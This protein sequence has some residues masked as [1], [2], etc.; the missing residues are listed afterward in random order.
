MRAKRTLGTLLLG[1]GFLALAGQARAQTPSLLKDINTTPP[2][3][4]ASYPYGY[5]PTAPY[6]EQNRFPRIGPFFY[7]RAKTE[8]LATSSTGA[9]GSPAAPGW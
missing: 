7:F 1:L 8:A 4:I 2:A 5:Q 9:W 6:F 3:N